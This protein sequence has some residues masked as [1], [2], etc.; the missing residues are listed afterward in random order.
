MAKPPGKNGERGGHE[1]NAG[2][3][4][5]FREFQGLRGTGKVGNHWFCPEK[6][7]Y[8]KKL[9]K[10]KKGFPLAGGGQGGGPT[11]KKIGD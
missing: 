10:K 7:N 6:K 11:Q 4:V 8:R 9:L 5:L 1:K 2:P 3:P